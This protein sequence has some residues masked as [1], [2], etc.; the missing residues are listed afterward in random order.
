GRMEMTIAIFSPERDKTKLFHGSLG[1]YDQA[2]FEKGRN[3]DPLSPELLYVISLDNNAGTIIAVHYANGEHDSNGT[4]YVFKRPSPNAPYALQ[5][6]LFG[7]TSKTATDLDTYMTEKGVS[8]NEALRAL[9]ADAATKTPN[10]D[11]KD[12]LT[13]R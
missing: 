1:V 3:V 13:N 5:W 11:S 9:H 4:A 6:W 12:A 10:L 7:Q 8:L 2:T